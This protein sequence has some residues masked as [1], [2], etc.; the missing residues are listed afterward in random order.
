MQLES[1]YM[2]AKEIGFEAMLAA[3]KFPDLQERV[4]AGT[5]PARLGSFGDAG[6]LGNRAGSRV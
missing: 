1:S 4:D 6:R 3:E 2:R 5:A